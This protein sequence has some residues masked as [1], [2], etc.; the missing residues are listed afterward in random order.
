[1]LVPVKVTVPGPVLETLAAM[2]VLTPSTEEMDKA[3]PAEGV[4]SVS[5]PLAMP[6]F[7]AV[8]ALVPVAMM[9]RLELLKYVPY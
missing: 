8:M 7:P 2:L 3:S 4:E 5:V 9:V 6:M 1:M